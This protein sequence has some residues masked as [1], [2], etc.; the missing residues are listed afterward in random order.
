MQK[1]IFKR[2]RAAQRL[3][4]F[5]SHRPTQLS[6]KKKC[7]VYI[8]KKSFFPCFIAIQSSPAASWAATKFNK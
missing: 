5:G 1:N 2:N 4:T 3:Q 6:R 7:Y 8:F